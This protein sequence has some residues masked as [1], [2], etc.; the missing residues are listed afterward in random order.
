MNHEDDYEE[1]SIALTVD[2][3]SERGRTMT[4]MAKTIKDLK[5]NSR[6]Y[7]MMVEYLEFLGMVTIDMYVKQVKVEQ[8]IEESKITSFKP[9]LAH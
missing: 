7:N 5:E 6:E 9:K 3:L 1:H 2:I 4:T 8:A